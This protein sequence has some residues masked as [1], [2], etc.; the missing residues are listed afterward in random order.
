MPYVRCT[1][2]ILFITH[3]RVRERDRK[4]PLKFTITT[5]TK[6]VM[7]KGNK[8]AYFKLSVPCQLTTA[9]HIGLKNKCTENF[10][11]YHVIR[12]EYLK[13]HY[14]STIRIFF[15]EKNFSSFMREKIWPMLVSVA[16]AEE[17]N[18]TAALAT[19][20]LGVIKGLPFITSG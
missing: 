2:R 17:K 4:S 20:I 12:H 14:R 15:H 3:T 6:G 13:F 1:F 11:E 9:T 5:T 7:L 8:T 10:T 16:A 18:P 19:L